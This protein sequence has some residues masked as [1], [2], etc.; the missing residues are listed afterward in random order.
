MS[1]SVVRRT[2]VL[3]VLSV[4]LAA[5][6]S[7]AAPRQIPR[8]APAP[9]VSQLW[10]RLTALWSDIGCGLDPNG[11]CHG[12]AASQSDIGCGLDPSGTC[13]GSA[14]PQG[15]IGCIADPSGACRP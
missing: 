14:L 11:L 15:D 3:F 8:A 7:A 9:L 10:S 12:S 4:L 6:W 13:H 5:P 1:R 2:A